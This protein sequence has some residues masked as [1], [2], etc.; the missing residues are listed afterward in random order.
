[1][2]LLYVVAAGL[3][4]AMAFAATLLLLMVVT[5]PFKFVAARRN[6]IKPEEH[7]EFIVFWGGIALVMALIVLAFSQHIV[8]FD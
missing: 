2:A 7:D 4:L 5:A 6:G 1:M 8:A 3:A